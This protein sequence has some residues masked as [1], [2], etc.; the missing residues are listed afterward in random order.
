MQQW[1]NRYFTWKSDIMLNYH[2]KEVFKHADID[3]W[4][5]YAA[6]IVIEI[7]N[8]HR[9][10]RPMFAEAQFVFSLVVSGTSARSY[11]V[12]KS[13]H[14]VTNTYFTKTEKAIG[15]TFSYGQ[16]TAQRVDWKWNLGPTDF[17]NC[18]STS[19]YD[20]NYSIL[21]SRAGGAVTS[22]RNFT[23]TVRCKYVTKISLVWL[24]Y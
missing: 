7:W 5:F 16:K 3:I 12:R 11:T 6:P 17:N 24:P 13:S 9:T 1:K 15:G 19:L 14:D 22:Q 2:L 23:V 10:F 4:L 21:V 8:G 18:S 20:G